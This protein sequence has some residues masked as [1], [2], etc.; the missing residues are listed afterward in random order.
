MLVIL[1]RRSRKIVFPRSWLFHFRQPPVGH[2]I[3][4]VARNRFAEAFDQLDGERINVQ[5]RERRERNNKEAGRLP[6]RRGAFEPPSRDIYCSGTK[7]LPLDEPAIRERSSKRNYLR[8]F[9]A[10]QEST[11]RPNSPDVN[12]FCLGDPGQFAW[13]RIRGPTRLGVTFDRLCF[14]CSTRRR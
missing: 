2:L 6:R 1:C 8:S 10:F 12:A 5:E 3:C 9:R 7:L 14:F 13:S 4:R 11:P